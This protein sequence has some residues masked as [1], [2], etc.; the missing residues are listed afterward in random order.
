MRA[1]RTKRS[2]ASFDFRTFQFI[3]FQRI[4]YDAWFLHQKLHS[5]FIDFSRKLGFTVVT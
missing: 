4:E 3:A 1:Y 2:F 5:A